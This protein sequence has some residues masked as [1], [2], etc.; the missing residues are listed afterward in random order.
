MNNQMKAA[1]RTRAANKIRSL[2]SSSKI[3]DRVASSRATRSP[4]SRSSRS[5]R[6]N[7]DAPQC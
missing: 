2:V 4:D 1:S 3:P 7:N 6:H 5:N